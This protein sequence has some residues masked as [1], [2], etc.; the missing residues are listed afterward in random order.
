MKLKTYVFGMNDKGGHLIELKIP[1]RS[2][3]Q[4]LQVIKSMVCEEHRGKHKI[5][6]NAIEDFD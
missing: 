1:A 5:W 6:L 4:A 2:E 3:K